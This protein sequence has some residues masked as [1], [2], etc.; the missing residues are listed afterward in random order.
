[1][2]VTFEFTEEIWS[3]GPFTLEIPDNKL[4]EHAPNI[5]LENT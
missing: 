2:K 4:I 1:M 5:N 3:K